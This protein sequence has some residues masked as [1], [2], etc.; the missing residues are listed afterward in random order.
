MIFGPLQGDF[1][2]FRF[3]NNFSS[4]RASAE[5]CVAIWFSAGSAVVTVTG[6]RQR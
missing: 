2:I 5:D 6:E 1:F 3:S 4:S